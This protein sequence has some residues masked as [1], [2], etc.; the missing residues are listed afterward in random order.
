MCELLLAVS[1]THAL[2]DITRVD[3]Y[4]SG[5]T[6]RVLVS[7]VEGCDQRSRKGEV[8][9]AQ[10][11]I[12]ICESFGRL[13]LLPVEKEQALSRERRNREQDDTP[14]RERAIRVG[15]DR[16]HRSVKRNAH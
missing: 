6:S 13:A 8:R 12:G 15:K 16:H 3:R 7:R 5:V 11:G 9:I 10:S 4:C 2:G 1:K 14:R